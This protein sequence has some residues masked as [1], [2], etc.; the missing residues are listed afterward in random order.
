VSTA[1]C[2]TYD[3]DFFAG[4]CNVSGVDSV[5][6]EASAGF[7][8]KFLGDASFSANIETVL[9]GSVSVLGRAK[10]YNHESSPL[11]FETVLNLF[12]PSCEEDGFGSEVVGVFYFQR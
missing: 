8:E 1:T 9:D 11:T 12:D 2:V 5:A 7:G 3:G 4:G 6:L 10:S